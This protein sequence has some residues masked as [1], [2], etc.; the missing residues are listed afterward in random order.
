MLIERNT[1]DCYKA[2][3]MNNHI[4]EQFDG[5][6]T[7]IIKNGMFVNLPN[8]VECFIR[9]ETLK[10]NYQYDQFTKLIDL[11]TGHSYKIG[12]SVSITCTSADVNSGKIDFELI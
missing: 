4:G 6:I 1:A 7:S 3:Y 2:E 11:K 8:T 10:G 5:I 12:Q 9:I